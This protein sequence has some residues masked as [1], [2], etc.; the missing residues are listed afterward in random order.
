MLIISCNQT[1]ANQERKGKQPSKLW[2]IIRM[3]Y[4]GL[5]LFYLWT[6]GYI[7]R[8]SFWSQL[9]ITDAKNT[10]TKKPT[11]I[12]LKKKKKKKDK[13]KNTSIVKPT[14]FSKREIV[15]LQ[16]FYNKS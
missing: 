2:N 9:C 15:S 3:G 13:A 10:S 12:S 14:N 7:V 6:I 16:H 1:Q 11:P 8:T 5:F 4:N